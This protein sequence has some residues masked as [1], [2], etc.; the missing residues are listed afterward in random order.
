MVVYKHIFRHASVTCLAALGVLFSGDIH[1]Q[2]VSDYPFRRTDLPLNVRVNDLISRLTLDEKVRLMRHEAPAIKRLGIPAYDWWNEALHG[3]A[4]TEERVTVFPQAIGLAATFDSAGVQRV[5]DIAATEGRALFNEDLKNGTTGRRYRGLTYWTPNVNIFRDPRWGR[6]QETYGEDPFLTG[7]LGAAMVRGLQGDDP[8]YYKSVGCAKHFA[9]HSGPEGN[10]HE[11][12]VSVTPYDLWDTYLPAFRKLVTEAK[13]GGVMC[14]YNR[15]DG[16]PCCGNNNLLR[17]ILRDLWG[18]DGY[19]TSDCWALADFVRSHRTHDNDTEAVADA[20]GSGTD[21]EC[22]DLYPRLAQAVKQGLVEERDINASLRRLFEVQFKLGMYDPQE[23]VPYSKIGREVIAC[24][25]HGEHALR[26]ARESMVLLRNEGGLLPLDASRIRRIALVGPNMNNGHT[27]LGNYNGVPVENVTPFMSLSRR[28]GNRMVIDTMTATDFLSPLPAGPTFD[29]VASRAAQADVIV[30]VGGISADYEGEA[31]DAGAAGYGAFSGGDRTTIALPAVQTQLLKALKATGRPVILVNMS[32]S[33]MSLE[34]ES[35]HLDAILQAWYGGQATG[36]A[37]TD[38]LFGDYN[39]SGRMPLTTYCSDADLPPFEDYSMASRT[40]RYFRGPVRYPFGYGLS[41][42]TFAYDG[43]QGSTDKCA[44]GRNVTVR[45][46]VRNT[47]RRSGDEVVQL[48][49]E[50]APDGNQRRPVRALKG[51]SRVPLKA[52][53]QRT[54]SFLLTPEDLALTDV[55]GNLVESAGPVRI[56]VGG[57][58][59]GYSEGGWTRL[60]LT[61]DDYIVY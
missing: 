22:G 54:V 61:G 17:R 8:V 16:Q 3:V 11:F 20:L 47:G 60:E 26:M 41:Y 24:K 12:N 33:V 5:G 15:L 6:G 58:Q 44:T 25:A 27:Q 23:K 52:G 46:T 32:G 29:E 9:V 35:A 53:E 10:R 43:V 34:W 1:A 51:F 7:R 59:P 57:G 19:V 13:V 21:L 49:V 36:D 30:F 38:I 2:E 31:G 40:Y 28:Y 39:P 45:A 37:I 14:A 55:D 56:Y 42:T 50:H 48:Y 4:R 18:F